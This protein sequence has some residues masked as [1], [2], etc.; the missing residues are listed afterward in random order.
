MDSAAQLDTAIE[1]VTPENISFQYEVVGPFRRLPAFILD[2]SIRAVVLLLAFFVMA[3]LGWLVGTGGIALMI[4]L[5]FM[6]EWFYGGIF[7]TYM[8]GQTPGK[9]IMGIRVVS[10]E[11]HPIS[12]VQAVMR[13]I[14]R[15]VDMMPLVPL[16]AIEEDLAWITVPTFAIGL[17]CQMFSSRF[18]RL[19]D[20]ACGTMVVVDERRRR[21]KVWTS[22]EPRVVALAEAIPVGF[23]ID[24]QLHKALA[25]YVER[26]PR[27]TSARRRDIARHLAVPLIERFGLPPD[28]NYDLLLCA[29]HW[30]NQPRA[31]IDSPNRNSAS[32]RHGA[33]TSVGAASGATAD[34][35]ATA[36]PRE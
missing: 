22:D 5:W 29:L 10:T 18:Q 17:V 30:K 11:G 36:S 32:P 15:G 28:T 12:G 25:A 33:E 23:P 13:N 31:P 8:N 24:R 19:G 2:L 34:S 14:L 1:I 35:R 4:V 3:L 20:I 9:R 6:L 27:I 7:E 26:R 21:P 16:S